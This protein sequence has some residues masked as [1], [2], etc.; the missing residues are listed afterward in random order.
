[1]PNS[2]KITQKSDDPEDMRAVFEQA[3]I[4]ARAKN[5]RE[6]AENVARELSKQHPKKEKIEDHYRQSGYPEGEMDKDE[7]ADED[8]GTPQEQ[9]EKGRD[10]ATEGSEK[11]D[12]D[13][14][15]EQKPLSKTDM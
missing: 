8:E 10:D 15:D 4:R 2:L 11:I 9:E 7:D 5:M 13:E 1:M 6:L 14:E 3:K 12:A